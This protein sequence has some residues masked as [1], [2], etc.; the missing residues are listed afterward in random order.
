MMSSD[1][2]DTQDLL[3]SPA[4]LTKWIQKG[5]DIHI[6]DVRPRDERQEWAIPESEHADIYQELK[7]GHSDTLKS[8]QLPD[9]T[10]I[11]TVCGAGKTSLTAARQLREEGLDSFSLEGGMKAWNYA[12]DTAQLTAAGDVTIVQ[13]RRLAKGCLSYII[14]SGEE[15]VVIDA[16]LDPEIYKRLAGERGWNIRR[17]M[18]T[19]LHADFVSR[20]RELADATQAEYMLHRSADTEFSYTPVDDLQVVAFGNSEITVLHTPGHTPE[21]QSFQVDDEAV[22]TGDTLFTDGVGRPDLKADRQQAIR[23]ATQLHTSLRELLALGEET[24]VFPAHYAASIRIGSPM[25]HSTIGELAGSLELLQFS[26]DTFVREVVSRI[27]PTPSNYQ[28]I[29][30]LNRKGSYK[31]HALDELEA[32]ANRCA[33]G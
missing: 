5:E 30:T 19:H 4:Q 2:T 26:R 21:S 27:P 28:T 3:I 6:L 25:I 23:K 13:V 32:G 14:G 16:S 9:D 31:G 18:D 7:E 17:V 22:F 29:S 24:R 1:T 15:A 20:S 12:W 11:V 33:V 8:M 10:P